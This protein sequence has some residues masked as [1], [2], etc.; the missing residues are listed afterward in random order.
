MAPTRARG[1]SFQVSCDFYNADAI[2]SALSRLSPWQFTP[3]SAALDQVGALPEMND[4]TRR[5]FVVLLTD[6]D[7][8][9]PVQDATQAAY[10]SNTSLAVDSLNRL[11][12]NGVETFVIGFGSDVSPARLDRLAAAGGK[13]RPSGTCANPAN[14][15]GPRIPCQYYDASDLPTLNATFDEIASVAQGELHGNSCDDSCYGIGGCPAGQRCTQNLQSYDQGKYRLNLGQCVEDPCATVTCG[16]LQFCRDGACVDACPARCLTGQYCDRGTCVD[17]PCVNGS[18]CVCPQACDKFLVCLS[19][20]CQDNPCR[21]VICPTKAPYCDRGSCYPASSP[22]VS[23]DA[24]RP[25]A[26]SG[27]SGG[28]CSASGA[29]L[30]VPLAL[31]L[32][33]LL[34]FRLGRAR[35]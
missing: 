12:A 16:A 13:P 5:R 6:G 28:G 7:P 29:E 21:Y 32:A 19:G 30:L 11:R 4:G 34:A 23:A 9:C 15:T 17:D 33:P 3:T 1:A 25:D 10:D 2:A 26:G 31:A 24:G 27:G 22:I 8:T 14:P 20:T 35:R 18:S